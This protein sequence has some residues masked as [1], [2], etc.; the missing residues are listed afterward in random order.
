MRIINNFLKIRNPETGAFEALPGVVSGPGDF[1][2]GVS[3]A[4]SSGQQSVLVNSSNNNKN[5]DWTVPEDG[6]YLYVLNVTYQPS[7]ASR[8]RVITNILNASESMVTE[9]IAVTSVQQDASTRGGTSNIFV[10]QLEAGNIV[11]SI[12]NYGAANTNQTIYSVAVLKIST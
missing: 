4:Y 9:N 10:A 1:P 12:L 5:V 2:G 11:R 6:L 8:F 7:A 3:L